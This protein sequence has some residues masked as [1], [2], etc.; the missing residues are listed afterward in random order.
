[1][2]ER[3]LQDSYRPSSDAV[4]FDGVVRVSLF[5]EGRPPKGSADSTADFRQNVEGVGDQDGSNRSTQNDD[6]FR[7]L[8][9]NLQIA[10]FHQMPGN[11]AA[12]DHHNSYDRKHRCP[13][14]RIAPEMS[15]ENGHAI[16]AFP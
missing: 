1:M 14:L 15:R 8:H 11:D 12:K 9:Q 2:R 4:L 7:G 6:Q 16:S 5:I 10:V 13:N 3:L